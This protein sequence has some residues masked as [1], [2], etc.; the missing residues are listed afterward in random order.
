M[1]DIVHGVFIDAGTDANVHGFGRREEVD[2]RNVI[3]GD[4]GGESVAKIP[5]EENAV[6]ATH[7]C[8]DGLDACLVR[9]GGGDAEHEGEGAIF[10]ARDTAL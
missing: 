5:A 3:V 6:V 7:G 1:N 9:G 8:G 10:G 4:F 2:D